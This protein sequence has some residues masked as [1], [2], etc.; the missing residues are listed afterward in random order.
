[1][2][3]DQLSASPAGKIHNCQCGKRMSSIKCDFHPVCI[4]CRGVD[5]DVNNY[6][7]ECTNVDDIT[8]TEYVKHKFSLKHK[9]LSKR[10]LKDHLLSATVVD[11][12]AVIADAPSPAEQ[13]AFHDLP[14]VSSDPPNPD[15]SVDAKLSGVKLK[16]IGQVCSLFDDFA[17]SLEERFPR[18]GKKFR[19]F[20]PGSSSSVAIDNRVASDYINQDVANCS[21]P[22]TAPVAME[23]EHTP[24]KAPFVSYTGHLEITL[25]GLA[26]LGALA[27]DSTLTGMSFSDLKATVR[28]FESSGL[29]IPDSSST[30]CELSLF[31]LPN[32]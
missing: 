31:I 14:S 10:K 16:L 24:D 22:A 1:M 3:S 2:D 21:F 11:D 26:A 5:C 32:L 9:L 25:G 18:I 28:F 23:S 15:D 30:C 29:G 27:G 7:N 17:K 4:T 19:Q 13:L 20:M 12:S 8:M 6:R